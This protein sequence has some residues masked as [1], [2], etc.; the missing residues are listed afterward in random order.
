MKTL[1]YVFKKAIVG[2]RFLYAAVF[3]LQFFA[4]AATL[5]SSFLSKVLVDALSHELEQ[6]EFIE[7]AVVDMLTQGRGNDYLYDHLSILPVAL[8]FSTIATA[9]FFWTRAFLRAWVSSHINKNL[10]TTLHEHLQSLPYEVFVKEKEGDLIQ[11]CTRDVDL[12]RRFMVM[13]MSQ[14]TYTITMVV[15]AFAVLIE[16]DARLAGVSFVTIPF[17]FIYSF[18]M[19]RLV[20]YRYRKT[21]DSEADVVDAISQ[22]LNGARIVKAY[23]QE[24]N[25][26]ALFKKSLAIYG[27]NYKKH[28][29]ASAFFYSSSDIFIFLA[30]SLAVIYAIYLAYIKEI[31]AGT[32]FISYTFVNMMVWPLRDMA[33]TLSNLGQTLASSDRIHKLLSMPIEERNTGKTMQ[34][35]GEIEFDHVSFAYPDAPQKIILDDVSFSVKKGQTIAILGK[36]GSGKST[37]FSLLCHLFDNYTGTIRVD[38]VDIRE[39]SLHCLRSQVLPVLQDPFLFSM[40][41][42]ENVEIASRNPDFKDVEKAVSDAGLKGAIDLFPDGYQTRV[43]EKGVTLS[44]GQRQRIAIARALLA[45]PPILL[46]DDS[47]SAVDMATDK[48]I[49]ENLARSKGKQTTLMI[50]HRIAS[51][52]DADLILVMEEGRIAAI[53]THEE[54]LKQEGLYAQIAH[55][56]SKMKGESIHG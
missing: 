47:L 14:M 21:D 27:D 43:G 16:I 7:S 3:V 35:Q 54:L 11:T 8:V 17:L 33:T 10:Q 4:V 56:Q 44:G 2:T 20:R 30:R 23:N 15:F 49:R 55:I 22:N 25:E 24:A 41:L 40:S 48:L 46:L 45:N 37:L 42:Q 5:F 36:I 9:F 28:T 26:I 50:T 34:I 12:V 31:T 38:G 19:I 18:F 51:A 32:I 52:K 53:G 13:R 39:L 6:A 1:A 29:L